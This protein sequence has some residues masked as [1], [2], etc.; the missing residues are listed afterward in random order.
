MDPNSKCGVYKGTGAS[1]SVTKR[2]I[3][4][5]NESCTNPATLRPE[6]IAENI[7]IFDFA[8]TLRGTVRD[9]KSAKAELE[10]AGQQQEPGR[11]QGYQ[12]RQRDVLCAPIRSQPC[13]SPRHNG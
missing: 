8:L 6:R 4:R 7:D 9:R 13:Q 10:Q 12:P 5:L 11:Q 1:N 3:D 2:K